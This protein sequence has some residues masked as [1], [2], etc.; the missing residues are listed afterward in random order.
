[1]PRKLVLLRGIGCHSQCV[2]CRGRQ[3]WEQCT[4]LPSALAK[5]KDTLTVW[6]A[7]TFAFQSLAHA[8]AP[9]CVV[10]TL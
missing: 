3:L 4:L 6:A 1:M 5:H 2:C 8:V 10:A 9:L 7:T